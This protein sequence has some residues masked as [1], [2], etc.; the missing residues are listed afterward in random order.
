MKLHPEDPRLTALLLG[1]LSE[2]EAKDVEQAIAEDPALQE[3]LRELQDVCQMLK[4]ELEP[5]AGA[6][7]P[8]QRGKVLAIARSGDSLNKPKS[9]RASIRWIVPL[10]AAAAITVGMFVFLASQQ[11]KVPHPESVSSKKEEKAAP[12][13]VRLHPA[14]GP[15]DASAKSLAANPRPAGSHPTLPPLLTR[16]YV[17]AAEFPTIEL[18]VQSGKSSLEWIR[19]AILTRH[20]RPAHEE[21]RVEEILN[22][23]N[24]RPA[25][26]TVV[27][28]LPV[29]GWHPDDRSSGQTS[30]AA[31]IAAESLACPWK[32]SA[33]LVII[34]VRGNPNTDCNIK[35]VFRANSANVSRYRLLGFASAV[36]KPDE[37]MPT[38]L[39]AKGANTVAIEIEPRG[40][41]T[42]LG[43]IE[44]S[45]NDQAAAP[46]PMNRHGSSEPSDDAR[47]AALICTY[48]QWLAD[49]PKGLV[50]IEVLAAL[51]RETA[52]DS[53][54]GDRVEFLH[55]IDQ[56][57][58]L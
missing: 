43:S 5:T 54:S 30:H 8:E 17:A 33:T 45:V 53:L 27:S 11:H 23:F 21:I 13:R 48:A 51:A 32:P 18:P 6:L 4:R 3:A 14:P 16:G 57:L 39:P 25:G 12:E 50:D 52:S 19:Q 10:A 49:D 44:W 47:F 37:P 29:A 31:T 22:S 41:A 26:V 1:E 20:E 46:V 28:R 36:G 15:V 9:G 40:T 42:E 7:A 34:T 58:G 35:A 2:D 24:L 38:L 56:S 55:L